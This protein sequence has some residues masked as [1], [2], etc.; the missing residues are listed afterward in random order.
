MNPSDVSPAQ[1]RARAWRRW[2]TLA[3]V[4][5]AVLLLAW[6]VWPHL[7]LERLIAEEERLRGW[8]SAHP[9]AV[10]AGAFAGYVTSV[11]L[12]LPGASILTPLAGWLF[13][14]WRGL[15]FVSFAST[16]GA[17][18]AF[19]L[20][21]YVLRDGIER[22]FRERVEAV[23]AALDRDGAYYLLT[24][25]LVPAFPF[26]LINLVLGVTRLPVWTFWWVSQLGMLPATCVLVYAGSRVPTLREL[27][28]A[29]NA[30][31][32]WDLLA[33]LTAVGLLPLV[34]RYL[35]QRSSRRGRDEHSS[36]ASA[37]STGRPT[38]W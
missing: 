11:G 12:S 15:V 2:G 14:F 32:R 36:T 7:T 18:V 31:M 30:L 33:A 37:E 34:L 26:F 29:Q 28:T 24:L 4:G 13:G 6:L 10:Y 17:T 22:R 5:G 9:V 38:N 19:L 8:K 25:R 23:N 3:G 35:V 16:S 20:S 21:R 27:S 1:S